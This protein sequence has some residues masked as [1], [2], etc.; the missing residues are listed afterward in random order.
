MNHQRGVCAGIVAAAAALLY[1]N[2][3]T[4]L[5]AATPAATVKGAGSLDGVWLNA[6][7]KG[8]SSHTEL[9]RVLRTVDGELPPLLP[10]ASSLLNERI[11]D[12]VAGLPFASTLAQCLPGG[13]PLMLFGDDVPLQILEGNRFRVIPLNAS[14][15]QD[16]DPSFMGDAVGHWDGDTL[17]VDNVGLL[18]RTTLD[19]IGMPHT[20]KLH[21]IERYRRTGPQ[22]M[23]IRVTIDDP[24]A[25]TRTWEA[26]VNYRRAPPGTRVT[27]DICENNRNQ[28]D[29]QGRSGFQRF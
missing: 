3:G 17:V 4:A 23:Q 26:K 10:W 5:L 24:G 2:S 29:A 7:Y 21:V 28:P 11:R 13:I 14:H 12:S 1:F 25:F 22:S 8:S 9:E 18:E 27:E 16:I 6:E 19:Q 20:D 15:P